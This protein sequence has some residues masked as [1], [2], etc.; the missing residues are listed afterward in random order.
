[1]LPEDEEE[2]E[3]KK[4]KGARVG[5]E[6]VTLA[7]LH[8]LEPTQLCHS[9]VYYESGETKKRNKSTDRPENPTLGKLPVRVLAGE[10]YWSEKMGFLCWSPTGPLLLTVTLRPERK[11]PQ[12]ETGNIS[13]CKA[14]IPRAQHHGAKDARDNQHTSAFLCGGQNYR[15]NQVASEGKYLDQSL[16]SSSA[17]PFPVVAWGWWGPQGK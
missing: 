10:S 3:N 14:F 17:P 11:G 12:G 13:K 5:R 7:S 6:A 2:L 4:Q 16:E 1:M 15:F 9:D 8:Y